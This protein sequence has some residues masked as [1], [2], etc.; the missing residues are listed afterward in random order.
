MLGGPRDMAEH[1]AELHSSRL[2]G[3]ISL[4]DARMR[5]QQ[6]PIR[7]DYLSN[8]STDLKLDD[9]VA[10]LQCIKDQAERIVGPPLRRT[11]ETQTLPSSLLP[12]T[13]SFLLQELPPTP[14]QQLLQVRNLR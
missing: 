13:S 7:K 5:H 10:Y 2:L 14:P 1:F 11:Q 8:Q 12:I 9:L 6:L 3:A 4:D